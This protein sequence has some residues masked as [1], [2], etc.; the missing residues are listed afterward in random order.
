MGARESTRKRV[1]M[2]KRGFEVMEGVFQRYG[3]RVRQ[4]NKTKNRFSVMK[5]VRV[6]NEGKRQ[7][8]HVKASP[9]SPA[10]SVNMGRIQVNKDQRLN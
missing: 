6:I 2:D 7:Y 5:R 10:L 8:K 4:K 3:D 9:I 1:L